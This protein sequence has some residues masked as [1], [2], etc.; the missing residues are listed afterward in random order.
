MKRI[1]TLH[2]WSIECRG[3][4]YSLLGSVIGD[5]RFDDFEVVRT[6]MIL[7][8]DFVKGIAETKNTIYHLQ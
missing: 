3:D 6:S 7:N 8:I 1:S 4:W 5:D 2:N